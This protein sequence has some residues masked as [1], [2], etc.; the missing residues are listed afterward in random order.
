MGHT[1]VPRVLHLDETPDPPWGTLRSRRLYQVNFQDLG[2]VS[3]V[4]YTGGITQ[5][6]WVS[7]RRQGPALELALEPAQAEQKVL[8][9]TP[10]RVGYE[11][12][13]VSRGYERG[14]WQSRAGSRRSAL[15]SVF[16]AQ[17][18]QSA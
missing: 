4:A 2:R 16:H 5:I 11:A 18:A 3:G 17:N 12:D 8:V 9:Q 14:E 7:Y 13:A 1:K 15:G 6:H 10:G